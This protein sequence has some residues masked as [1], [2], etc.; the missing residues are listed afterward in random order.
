MTVKTE[1]QSTWK[2]R[3][4][5]D[6]LKGGQPRSCVQTAT[7]D[8]REVSTRQCKESKKESHF[9]VTRGAKAVDGGGWWITPKNDVCG[10]GT[11]TGGGSNK[12]DRSR[13]RYLE[14]KDVSTA[15]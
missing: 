14:G 13:Q 1:E 4:P 8:P 2:R 5:K 11:P 7:L 12:G 9:Q 15:S 6:A 10:E 3:P